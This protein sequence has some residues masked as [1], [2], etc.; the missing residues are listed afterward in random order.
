MLGGN[1]WVFLW[2]GL[3]GRGSKWLRRKWRGF[4]F[5][6]LPKKGWTGTRSYRWILGIIGSEGFQKSLRGGLRGREVFFC[7][8]GRGLKDVIEE[9]FLMLKGFKFFLELG[10]HHCNDLDIITHKRI[11]I[12]M[13]QQQ[14]TQNFLFP[15]T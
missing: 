1:V 8:F 4:C 10:K 9:M 3:N 2:E 15:T 5:Q 12:K 13:E 6:C 7:L 11:C 14:L